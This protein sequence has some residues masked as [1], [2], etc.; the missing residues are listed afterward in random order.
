MFAILAVVA[1][2]SGLRSD[3]DTLAIIAGIFWGST[4]WWLILSG[5]VSMVREHFTESTCYAD[6]SQHC[7]GLALL[8]LWV[9]V[10]SVVG[11][12]G[13]KLAF[14]FTFPLYLMDRK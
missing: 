2:F 4:L 9:V 5:G 7:C 12:W 11:F 14:K 6:Q 3:Q 8:A 1:T 10:S 13:L